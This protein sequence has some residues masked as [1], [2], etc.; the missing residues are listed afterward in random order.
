MS[1]KH[2]YVYTDFVRKAC[3]QIFVGAETHHRE[4]QQPSNKL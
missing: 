1:E 4:Q 2:T 3:E